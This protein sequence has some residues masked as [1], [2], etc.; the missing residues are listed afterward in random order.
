M[1]L[2]D[3][4]ILN[5]PPLEQHKIF[6]FTFYGWLWYTLYTSFQKYKVYAKVTH[7]FFFFTWVQTDIFLQGDQV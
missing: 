3:A 5:L 1:Y 7:E 6:I 4:S 2:Y